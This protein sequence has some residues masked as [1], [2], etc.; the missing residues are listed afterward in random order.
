[1]KRIAAAVM[2]LCLAPAGAQ[3]NERMGGVAAGALGALV[4]GPARRMG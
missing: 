4:L 3:A 1:M 2:A